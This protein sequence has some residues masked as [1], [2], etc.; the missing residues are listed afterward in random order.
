MC[1]C[2]F[3]CVWVDKGEPPYDPKMIQ[4]YERLLAA[5]SRGELVY[6]EL[7]SLLTSLRNLT[8]A[9]NNSSTNVTGEVTETSYHQ[10]TFRS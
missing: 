9:N 10:Y 4:L 6:R 5:E 7:S 2:V 3:L 1:G 8:I